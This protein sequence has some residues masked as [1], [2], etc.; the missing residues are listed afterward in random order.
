MT[1]FEGKSEYGNQITFIAPTNLSI[2]RYLLK[3][4]TPVATDGVNDSTSTTE[5]IDSTG[6]GEASIARSFLAFPTLPTLSALSIL[7]ILLPM[8][9]P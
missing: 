5:P 8:L 3:T 7:L 9:L 6:T 2:R 1:F 4:H